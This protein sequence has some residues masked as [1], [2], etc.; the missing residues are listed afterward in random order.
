MNINLT[1]L[2]QTVTFIVFVWFTMKFVWPPIMA[3]LDA[4]RKTIADG[5][6]AAER[7]KRELELADQRKD[8]LVRE[9]KK[10]AQEIMSQA[11]KRAAE[12]VDESKGNAKLEA[13][14]ILAAAKTDIAQEINR[15]KEQLRASVA[16]LA[17][18]GA[19]KIIDKEIDAKT[20]AKLIEGVV[21]QL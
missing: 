9:A 10:Q 16:Q 19:S 1:L 5:L 2:L 3:A 6:A 4:R 17:V 12:I 21:N 11:E 20:H 13:D 18:A 8:E 7:G 15:A 14:R